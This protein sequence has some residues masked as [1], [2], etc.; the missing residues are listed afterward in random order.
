MK[1]GSKRIANFEP[2]EGTAVFGADGRASIRVHVLD[3]A[4]HA[5][6]MMA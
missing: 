6:V 3:M 5:R 1:P 4:G 2:R